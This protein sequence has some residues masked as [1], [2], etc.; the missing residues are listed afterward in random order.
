[1]QIKPTGCNE[2]CPFYNSDTNYDTCGY[3]TVV[4]CSLI[5][6][7]Q[8][9]DR[10]NNNYKHGDSRIS[11]YDQGDL[12]NPIVDCDYCEKLEI[13]RWNNG[14]EYLDIPKDESKCTCVYEDIEF[15]HP[16]KCPLRNENVV[17][18]KLK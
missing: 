12:T 3:D 16:E 17:I 9:Q 1:M 8:F 5:Q 7:L 18:E 2:T 6:F 4:S 11:V 10:E 15:K 14:E 13:E